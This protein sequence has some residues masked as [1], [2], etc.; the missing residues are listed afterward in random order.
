MKVQAFLIAPVREASG[1]LDLLIK[2]SCPDVSVTRVFDTLS[3]ALEA[4]DSHQPELIFL[5]IDAFGDRCLD[6]LIQAD[7]DDVAFILITSKEQYAL[8]AFRINTVGYLLKPVNTRQLQRCVQKFIRSRLKT[9]V[10]R[11]V[12]EQMFS[13][14]FENRQQQPTLSLSV[15]DGI[16]FIPVFDIWYI[17]ADGPYSEVY[18][19]GERCAVIAKPLKDLAARLHFDQFDRVHNSYFVNLAYVEKLHRD[20]YLILKNQ[21]HISVS[22]SNRKRVI[23]KLSM[24]A[25]PGGSGDF[26]LL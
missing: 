4:I 10:S 2:Y 22:R 21:K 20:G 1:R 23:E 13:A 25:D 18:Y 12:L 5:D 17:K 7:I 11:G 24:L 9:M 19:A 15:S 14:K 3:K 26:I 8:P 6:V 16:L